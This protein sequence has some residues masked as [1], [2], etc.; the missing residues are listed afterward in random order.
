MW[1]SDVLATITS[2]D[3]ADEGGVRVQAI[4]SEGIVGERYT[5]VVPASDTLVEDIKAA[6]AAEYEVYAPRVQA[7]VDAQ[8]ATPVLAPEVESLV[9]Y[10]VDS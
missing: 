2:I 8:N 1:R 7:L 4:F 6:M 9:G 10:T 3:P 5:F